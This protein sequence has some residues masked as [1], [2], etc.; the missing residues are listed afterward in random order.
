MKYQKRKRVVPVVICLALVLSMM[1]ASVFGVSNPGQ[2]AVTSLKTTK[3]A[4]KTCV[5]ISWSKAKNASGYSIYR[6]TGEKGTYKRIYS[7]VKNSYTDKK[8]SEGHTYYYKI[9][10]YRYV[11][12]KRLYGLSSLP[13]S[14]DLYFSTPHFYTNA[15]QYSDNE[16][17][18]KVAIGNFSTHPEYRYN[19]TLLLYTS[20]K[21]P[22]Y[23]QKI[24]GVIEKNA[25]TKSKPTSTV[26]LKYADSRYERVI[27]STGKGTY[28]FKYMKLTQKYPSVTVY[29]QTM[30][31]KSF[32]SAYS[33]DKD[34][35][36][37]YVLYRDK[38][39]VVRYDTKNGIRLSKLS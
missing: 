18:L 9:K 24:F 8:V 10:A 20:L 29:L 38:S 4:S 27:H 11:N 3:I 15:S 5:K 13:K 26:Y 17:R 14:I 7:T 23:K 35:L 28:D 16:L 37:F 6:A 19:K 12:G 1:P 36:K 33:P 2:A 34:V 32:Q 21:R 22:F 31:G 30:N 25:V 39:Y